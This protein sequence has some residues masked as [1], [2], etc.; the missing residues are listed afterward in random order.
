MPSEKTVRP[1]CGERPDPRPAAP[2]GEPKTVQV[3]LEVVTSGRDQGDGRQITS[4]V[5]QK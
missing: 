3:N 5:R 2:T 4:E 1:E